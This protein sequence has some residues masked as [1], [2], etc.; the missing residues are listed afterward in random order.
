MKA[1]VNSK[2]NLAF[3]S[4]KPRQYFYFKCSSCGE[5]S[6]QCFYSV[7][8]IKNTCK[9]CNMKAGIEKRKQNCLEKY[10]VDNPS[11]L[12]ST[13]EKIR[14]TN[15]IRYGATSPGKNEDVKNKQR[16]T[17]KDRYGDTNPGAQANHIKFL[18]YRD[19]QSDALELEW[20]DKKDFRGKY[21]E[22]GPILYSFKCLRCGNVFKDD[23]HSREPVCRVC[24]PSFAGKS[25]IEDEIY[26]FLKEKYNGTIIRHDRKL[27]SGKELD[28]YF[29]EKKLAIEFNGTWWHG[30]KFGEEMPVSEFKQRHEWKRLEC[31][32]HGIR[33][34]N[35]DE[36][37]Y[38]DRPKVFQSFMLD[39]LLDRQKVY[40]RDCILREV[41][42]RT[43]K[44]FCEKYH[45]NG[46]RA[47][48]VAYGLFHDNELL[49]VAS[50]SKHLKYGWECIRLCYKTGVSITGG[51]EKIQKHFGK[52]FLHYVNLNFFSGENKTGCGYRFVFHRTDIVYRNRLQTKENIMK[53][54]K[55]DYVYNSSLS[56]FQNCLAG[57][58]I[59]IFDCGNDIRVYNKTF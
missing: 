25:K 12:K 49:C 22:N 28:F 5:I 36:A 51:W 34:L 56:N 19:T 6:E 21:D 50:F 26:A 27:L 52:Q 57:G 43:A 58:G 15:L 32:K 38:L 35:I 55:K 44:E 20:L 42:K 45:V 2:E 31:Q 24:N 17:L 59:A 14:N 53:Y 4:I 7:K 47:S 46:W 29:P 40:A 41:D 9:K 37:D 54:V 48:S 8:S 3:D 1:Y 33:L 16:A 18:K 30:Y 10:G 23:F 13:Q 39:C 11:K